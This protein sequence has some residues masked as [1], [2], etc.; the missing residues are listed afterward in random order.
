[1]GILWG[2]PVCFCVI[3]PQRYTRE[4]M[5]KSESFTLSFFEEEYRDAL[6]LCGTRSGRG[7]EKVQAAGLTPVAGA[8]PQT[9]TFAEARLVIACRKIYF[10]DIDPAHFVDPSIQDSYPQKDYHR[11]YIGEIKNIGLKE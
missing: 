6:N 10:Q 9:T 4:F 1:M 8:L 11:M 5:E 7:F 2:R 3:R